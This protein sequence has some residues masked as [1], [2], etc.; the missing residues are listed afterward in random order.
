MAKQLSFTKNEQDVL[1]DFRQRINLAESTED[2]KKFFVYTVKELFYDVF[3]RKI[4]IVY[5]DVE[6]NFVE[7][8]YFTLSDR[9]LALDEFASVWNCSDLPNVL[10]RFAKSAI[11]RSKHLEKHPEKTDSKIRM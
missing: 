5:E 7:D 8:P 2:V 1:P 11:K 3:E 10:A 9:L 6:L 4:D